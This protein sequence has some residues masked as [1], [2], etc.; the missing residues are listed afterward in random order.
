MNTQ[1]NK[2]WDA[3]PNPL[4]DRATKLLENLKNNEKFV[5]KN[6]HLTVASKLNLP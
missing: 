5:R 4:N 6:L 2:V 3:S 1:K